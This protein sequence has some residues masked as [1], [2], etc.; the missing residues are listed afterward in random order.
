MDPKSRAPDQ[1]TPQQESQSS[2]GRRIWHHLLLLLQVYVFG[3]ILVNFLVYWD[4]PT[5]GF[6]IYGAPVFLVLL[7]PLAW[8][9]I[10]IYCEVRGRKHPTLPQ[11]QQNP[12]GA[13]G[14]EHSPDSA[15]EEVPESQ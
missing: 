6:S 7:F 15:R 2:I 3:E 10:Y 1:A 4:H 14:P 11:H 13:G 5:Y 12:V 9:T 8:I